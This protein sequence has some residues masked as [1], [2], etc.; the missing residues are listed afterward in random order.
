MRKILALLWLALFAVIPSAWGQ[1]YVDR[2]PRLKFGMTLGLNITQMKTALSEMKPYVD[3]T[4]PGFVVGST[5]TL[6]RPTGGLGGDL[7]MLLDMRSAKSEEGTTRPAKS[8]S[9]QIPLNLR[10]AL[11]VSE[12]ATPFFFVGPQLGFNVG[13]TDHLLATGYGAS[14]GHAMLRKWVNYK[15]SFS[16]N[17]GVGVLAMETVQVRLCYNLALKHSGEFQQVDLETGNVMHKGI[18]KMGAVQMIVSYLF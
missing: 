7:S 2:S 13:H 11:D 16:V 9:L 14:T 6:Y 12:I 10:Y 18:G 17:M 3:R 5:L 4:R 15:T 8:L 1:L